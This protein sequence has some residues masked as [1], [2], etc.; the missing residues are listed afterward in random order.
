MNQRI[1]R[2]HTFY[3]LG[4]LHTPKGFPSA[5]EIVRRWN[6]VGLHLDLADVERVR[7]NFVHLFPHPL[8][9]GLLDQNDLDLLDVYR[10][11]ILRLK[12]NKPL[13]APKTPYGEAM[14][15]KLGKVAKSPVTNWR[16]ELASFVENPFQRRREI[17]RVLEGLKRALQGK[18]T[19]SAKEIRK[20][21][22]ETPGLPAAIY[23]ALD[24][25]G[26]YAQAITP[27]H[28]AITELREL[29]K[30]LVASSTRERQMALERDIAIQLKKYRRTRRVISSITKRYHRNTRK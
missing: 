29:R 27:R 24:A 11:F 9:R 25:R 16:F 7:A 4:K 18:D 20:L 17:L 22:A 30:N 2:V 28:F 19:P 6:E 26:R 8:A 14:A 1:T 5:E 13:V 23:R 21:L 10:R 3:L 15:K 12:G